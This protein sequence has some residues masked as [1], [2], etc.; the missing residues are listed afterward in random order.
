[1]GTQSAAP[2]CARASSTFTS[3][4]RA[5]SR[6]AA[7]NRRMRGWTRRA[8]RSRARRSWRRLLDPAPPRCRRRSGV[9]APARSGRCGRGVGAAHRERVGL[10]GLR[11]QSPC[12]GEKQTVTSPMVIERSDGTP[13]ARSVNHM[14]A[15]RSTSAAPAWATSQSASGES[16]RGRPVGRTSPTVISDGCP[17]G[18]L[19]QL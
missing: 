7:M 17:G 11:S 12:S 9:C 14:L 19:R 15:K 6:R 8:S 4:K 10:C 2:S 3:C 1:M 5:R 13:R 18:P 16:G